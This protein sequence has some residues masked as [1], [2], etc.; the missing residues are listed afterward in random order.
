MKPLRYELDPQL[1]AISRQYDWADYGNSNP[2]ADIE[3]GRELVERMASLDAIANQ[4]AYRQVEAIDRW[5]LSLG[6]SEQ[7]EYLHYPFR[8]V[9]MCRRS[10][11]A[12]VMADGSCSQLE[13]RP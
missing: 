1:S 9:Q 5:W 8:Q 10:G 2:L 11:F 12:P 6:K 7:K 3:A 4:R 13:C